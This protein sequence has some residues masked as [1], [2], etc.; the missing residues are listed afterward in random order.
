MT[1]NVGRKNYSRRMAILSPVY[2][3]ENFWHT[4]RVKLAR[5]PKKSSANF[6]YTAP[7]LPCQNFGPRVSSRGDMHNSIRS[8]DGR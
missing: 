1:S 8:K 7:F 3:T 5:V 2:T 4:A 6:V